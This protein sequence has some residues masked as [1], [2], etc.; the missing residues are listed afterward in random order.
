MPTPNS[1]PRIA[2][3]LDENT[4]GD[5]SRYE[6]S[7][8]YFQAIDDA[9]GLPFGIPYLPAVIE[10][11]IENFD[12]LLTTGSRFAF[13]PDWYLEGEVT[14]APPSERFDI[15]RRVTT[16]FLA[17]DKP[18][19]GLCG[20]MQ[21]L[22]GLKGCKLVADTKRLSASGRDHCDP[23][24][25]HGI[26]LVAGTRLAE[27][28]SAAVFEVN[29]LHKESVAEV[30][31]GVVISAFAEDGV[32]EAIELPDQRFALGLQWHQEKYA[33]RDHPGNGVFTAFV[34]A[35]GTVP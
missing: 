2:V 15:E 11:A 20:G 24:A 27:I 19:L 3:L 18:V 16:G 30:P 21:V 9:G 34:A 28:A 25:E 23:A 33:G 12:G 17:R 8:K 31:D 10:Q 13:P 6:A 29:T 35:C 14:A 22:A 7:K 1:R 4:S 5:A 32:I 26:A